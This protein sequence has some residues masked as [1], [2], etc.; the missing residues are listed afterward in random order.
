LKLASF[1]RSLMLCLILIAA[2]GTTSAQACDTNA[3]SSKL[4]EAKTHLAAGETDQ[5]A[6]LVAEAQAAL[7]AC[8]TPAAPTAEAAPPAATT[9]AAAAPANATRRV[10]APEVGADKAIV[11]ISFANTSID[12]GSVDIYSDRSPDPLV[13][14]L[15]FGEA[16]E[17]VPFEAGPISFTARAAGSGK[18]GEM[19][20]TGRKDFGANSSWVVT[21]A[22][23]KSRVSLI[24]E[25]VSIVRSDYNDQ[26]RVRV[27]NFVQNSTIDLVDDGGIDFGSNLGW[28][29]IKDNMIDPG[30]HTLQ[31]NSGGQPLMDAMTFD[32][33][34]NTTYTL[35][36]I[37]QP[38]SDHPVQILSIVTPQETTRVRFVSTRSDTVELYYRPANEKVIE[39]IV[40][41]ATS[42]WITLEAGAVTFLAYA[43]GTGMGGRELGGIALQL[44]P[45]RDITITMSDT[46]MNVSDT[47][48]TPAS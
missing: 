1:I 28:V 11:F 8:S 5:A 35:Y 4:D 22:G 31:V 25:P 44:R 47:V 9:E 17:L 36:L 26:A 10:T 46:D 29:S 27:V 38:E 39:S 48:L 16:T 19:L 34:A 2:V 42:D 43:P 33:A 18:N 24:I 20:T 12:A 7:S 30:K 3:I 45:G 15:A 6:A 14:D 23:L 37:G 40:G 41:A 32:F 21:T 13:T